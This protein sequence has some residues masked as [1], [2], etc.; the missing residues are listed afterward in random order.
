[1][2]RRD[3]KEDEGTF[4]AMDIFNTLVVIMVHICKILQT[5]QVKYV[6]LI[7]CQLYPKKA[8][9]FLKM[10]QDIRALKWKN[11]IDVINRKRKPFRF[12]LPFYSI[13][14]L[15]SQKNKCNYCQFRI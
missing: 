2:G 4:M 7:V 8:A 12:G 15:L 9:N 1:M 10:S 11:P 13:I 6:R 5:V 3:C 14:N